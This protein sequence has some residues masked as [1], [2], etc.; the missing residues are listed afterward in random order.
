MGA[1]IEAVLR[2]EGCQPPPVVRTHCVRIRFDPYNH[3]EAQKLIRSVR[4]E[5]P[6]WTDKERWSYS[7]PDNDEPNVWLLDF[8]FRDIEDA[9]VFGLKYSR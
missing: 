5:F 6:K 7:V 4:Q 2:E 3:P 8:R 1:D 9:I